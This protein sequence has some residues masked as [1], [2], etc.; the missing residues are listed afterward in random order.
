MSYDRRLDPNERVVWFHRTLTNDLVYC[1]E[2]D[3][4]EQLY[5]YLEKSFVHPQDYSLVV[6]FMKQ[7]TALMEDKMI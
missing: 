5:E 6:E 4:I 1:V 2:I 3:T 7:L